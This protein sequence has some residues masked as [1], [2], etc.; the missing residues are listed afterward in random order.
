MR[1]YPIAWDG[2]RSRGSFPVRISDVINVLFA[3][4]RLAEIYGDSTS[5]RAMSRLAAALSQYREDTADDFIAWTSESG[6][7]DVVHRLRTAIGSHRMRSRKISD[8]LDS[9]RSAVS[10]ERTSGPANDLGSFIEFLRN[11]IEVGFTG[12]AVPTPPE[13][14]LAE[15]YVA[16]L[17]SVGTDRQNFQRRMVALQTDKRLSLDDLNEIV[18][19]YGGITKKARSRKEAIE[20][21]FDRFEVSA[22]FERKASAIDKLTDRSD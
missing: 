15:E 10:P 20:R 16:S 14:S 19:V 18:R 11:R 22:Q 2:L 5:S 13:Q 21:L 17:R 9:V 4:Q 12:K 8:Q 3:L 6:Q 1:K 7:E